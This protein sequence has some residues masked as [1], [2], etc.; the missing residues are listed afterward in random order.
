MYGRCKILYGIVW[1]QDLIFLKLNDDNTELLLV[2]SKYRQMLAL[3]PVL[4]GNEMI[5][6]T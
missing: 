3:L 4:V 5:M 6:R 2:N 1:Y